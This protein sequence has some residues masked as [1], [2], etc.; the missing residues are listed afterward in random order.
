MSDKIIDFNSNNKVSA[1]RVTNDEFLKAIFRQSW[2]SAHVNV[3]YDDPGSLAGDRRSS[4]IAW[5]GGHWGN[6]AGRFTQGGNQYFCISTFNPSPDGKDR[7]RKEL[8]K[9]THVIVIDDVGKGP[10]AKVDPN[11]PRLLQPSYKLETS[12]GNE[13]WGYILG[14]PETDRHRV[15][16]LLNGM[17]AAKLCIDGSDPGMKGVTRLVRLPQGTNNKQKYIEALGAPFQCKLNHWEPERL[18]AIEQLAERFSVDL[19][20][21]GA[22]AREVPSVDDP[23]HPSLAA[24]AEAFGINFKIAPGKYDV[25]CPNVDHHTGGMISGNDGTAIWTHEDG[26]L[27]FLC[28][29]GSCTDGDHPINSDDVMRLLYAHRPSLPGEIQNY[30]LKG[31]GLVPLMPAES[32]GKVPPIRGGVTVDHDTGAVENAGPDRDD[33]HLRC[34]SLS[35]ASDMEDIRAVLLDV[36]QI[37]SPMERDD[38]IDTIRAQTHKKIASLRSELSDI[39]KRNRRANSVDGSEPNWIHVTESLTPKTTI[40]NFYALMEHY[41]IRSR[42]NEM[43]KSIEVHIPGEDFHEDTAKNAQILRIESLMIQYGMNHKQAVGWCNF[44]AQ[45]D[46]YHPLREYLDRVGV[47]DG[48]D[49]IQLL[50]ET[51]RVPH[52]KENLRNTLLKRWLVSVV[53]AALRDTTLD[54]LDT[55]E[56]QPAPRGVLTLQGEQYMGKTRWFRRIIP[57]TMFKEGLQLGDDK[58]SIK[59]ATNCL[60]VEV[61]EADT[62]TKKDVGKVKAF[63]SKD[64]DEIRVPWDKAES[65]WPRRTVFA[66]TVNPANFLTDT[67]GNSRWWV[68]PVLEIDFMALDF[69]NIPQLW[70]QVE[71]MWLAGEP[72]LL[73]ESEMK[74]L[75]ASNVGSMALDNF[76]E[77]LLDTFD[78][79]NRES[80]KDPGNWMTPTE[81]GTAYTRDTHLKPPQRVG[82]R[83]KQPQYCGKGLKHGKREP[84][85]GKIFNDKTSQRW[86]K[87]PVKRNAV[88]EPPVQED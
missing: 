32:Q 55:K 33:L 52:G 76:D 53:A 30:K 84:Y 80:M 82:D 48:Q 87:M 75:N 6:L 35:S 2:L 49:R 5:A 83:L 37:M 66:G 1:R 18:F 3:F 44:A 70:L 79:D 22:G 85:N 56:S 15:E 54:A 42:Y 77:W 61:G 36:A 72:Y 9:A 11:D 41:S 19:T 43:T 10:S 47:W 71:Q 67:T 23:G 24:Y 13:Q 59:Q 20:A 16:A 88:M 68:V 57:K 58:D 12:P 45:R 29:H 50:A 8:F 74:A 34:M 46:T 69:I 73:T 7:R 40:E 39:I 38:Y 62:T 21:A 63:I 60:V 17:V 4:L 51:L 65:R 26:K 64:Y 28:H 81:I 14:F 86:W 78:W 25:V 31:S 27:G